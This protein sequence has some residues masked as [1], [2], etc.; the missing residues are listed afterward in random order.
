MKKIALIILTVVILA[1]CAPNVPAQ[2]TADIARVKTAAVATY[3][4]SQPTQEPP[5]P[6][7]VP[8]TAT[9]LPPATQEPT[10]VPT[11]T[12]KVPTLAP[13]TA[14]SSSSGGKVLEGDHAYL[15]DQSPRDF[16]AIKP[17]TGMPVY[18]TFQNVG[19]TTWTTK[20]TFR[21]FDGYKAWGETSV[22]LPHEVKPG[23]TVFIGM[24]VFPPEDPG[25]QYTTY[26]GLFNQDGERFNKVNYPFYVEK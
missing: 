9:Q 2:P 11:P 7:A 3:Q 21:Y 4:A 23:E 13:T 16:A 22:N 18:Y 25:G 14:P 17:G 6:T 1:A 15:A 10:L 26:W 20:Y 12:L 5:A 8:P 24:W 19:T